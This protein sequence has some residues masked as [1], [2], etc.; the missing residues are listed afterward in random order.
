MKS[1]PLAVPQLNAL[2]SSLQM[3]DLWQYAPVDTITAVDSNSSLSETFNLRFPSVIVLQ[4]T[5]R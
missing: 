1:N 4:Y 3:T 2:T 5:P